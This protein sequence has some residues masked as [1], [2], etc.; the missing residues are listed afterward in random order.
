MA[1]KGGP[2]NS[3]VTSATGHTT[4]NY[5]GGSSG[6]EPNHFSG[7]EHRS[8]RRSTKSERRYSGYAYSEENNA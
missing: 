4:L 8:E 6:D 3:N 2:K 7:V 5:S 1:G